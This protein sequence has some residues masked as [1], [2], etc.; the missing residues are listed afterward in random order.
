[1]EPRHDLGITKRR[2]PLADSGSGLYGFYPVCLGCAGALAVLANGPWS[3]SGALLAAALGALGVLGGW[4]SSRRYRRQCIARSLDDELPVAPASAGRVE[5]SA[6]S[7]AG[8]PS[9]G[10]GPEDPARDQAD[11]AQFVGSYLLG[12]RSFWREVIP[13]WTKQ[14]QASKNQMEIAVRELTARFSGIVDRL[15]ESVAASNAAKGSVDDGSK[16]LVAVFA[17]SETELGAVVRSLATSVRS[18]T[19]MLEKIQGLTQFIQQLQKMASDVG[20]IAGQTRLLSLNAAIEATRAGE[21]GRGFG[22]VADEVR[23]LSAL[24]AETG[25]RI[26]DNVGVISAAIVSVCRTAEESARDEGE[27]AVASEATIGSV[28]AAFR[29][30]TDALTRSAGV[31]ATGSLG[32]K[33]EVSQSLVQLQFQDRVGQMMSHVEHNIEGFLEKFEATHQEG[34]RRGVVPTL[35]PARFLAEL[36]DTYTMSE[37]RELHG[38]PGG[39]PKSTEDV[40]F[41]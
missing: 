33:H 2:G 15:D 22:V 7:G 23:K 37:E 20:R 16:G 6:P 27:A 31:L 41:F 40:T 28:L 12:W 14:L 30:V 3:L 10:A 19:A 17:H 38:H 26:A 13:V 36:R 1:M 39:P 9:A 5:A 21:L 24:S 11:S 32:I 25:Q 8:A 29:E 35:D 18:K 34:A 4:H